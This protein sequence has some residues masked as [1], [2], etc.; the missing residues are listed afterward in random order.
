MQVNLGN[1]KS[2]VGLYMEDLFLFAEKTI[3]LL[4]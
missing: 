2:W 1:L 4:A 3:L